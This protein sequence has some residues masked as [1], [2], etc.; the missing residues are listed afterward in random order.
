MPATSE[1]GNVF[2]RCDCKPRNQDACQ[3]SWYFD[4]KPRRA[5]RIRGRMLDLVGYE[6]QDRPTAEREGERI[7]AAY[8]VGQDPKQAIAMDIPTVRNLL[9]AY[10]V[11]HPTHR[12]SEDPFIWGYPFR[13]PDGRA[14]TVGEWFARD[15]D[16]SAMER[17]LEKRPKTAGNRNFARLRAAFNFAVKRKLLSSVPF[18]NWMRREFPRSRRLYDNEYEDLLNAASPDMQ[19]VIVAAVET[20][21]RLGEI[22]SLQWRQITFWPHAEIFVPAQKAKQKKD[23]RIPVVPELRK[24]LER[25]RLDPAGNAMGPQQYV[26]GDAVGRPVKSHKTAWRAIKLRA[27]G[28]TPAYETVT[29]IVDGAKKRKKRLT[30][31]CRDYLKDIGLRFHD[32]RR[33]AGSRWD[34]SGVVPIAQN[35]AQLGHM[36][37]SQTSTYVVSLPGNAHATMERYAEYRKNLDYAKQRNGGG[38][39]GGDAAEAGA[40]GGEQGQPV[41]KIANK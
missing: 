37:L 19:D 5:P 12:P 13:S 20:G 38:R 16:D 14:K 35:Q 24:I 8:A 22:T 11:Q 33:E 26:F 36:K 28:H 17:F 23:R 25:R 9:E 3:H 41:L 39:S 29:V 32:L 40:T 10:A 7:R 6:P 18:G 15:F 34:E 1:N 21:M 31:E 2:K 4:W 30:A 27:N